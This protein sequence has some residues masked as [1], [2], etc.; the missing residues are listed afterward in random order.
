MTA[1][2]AQQQAEVNAYYAGRNSWFPGER[3]PRTNPY[4]GT[5]LAPHFARGL[6]NVLAEERLNLCTEWDND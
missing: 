3:I 2:T 5:P 6:R 1:L 4:A